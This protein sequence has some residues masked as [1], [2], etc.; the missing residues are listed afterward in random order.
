MAERPTKRRKTTGILWRPSGSLLLKLDTDTLFTV[1]AFLSVRDRLRLEVCQQL[2]HLLRDKVQW[3][4]LD[5]SIE[6]VDSAPVPP[7]VFCHRSLQ[8]VKVRVRS[9]DLG[10]GGV[11]TLCSLPCLR[12]LHLFYMELRDVGRSVDVT[13]GQKSLVDLSIETLSLRA[14][15]FT[16]RLQ[17]RVPLKVLKLVGLIVAG[18]ESVTTQ[19]EEFEM[20]RCVLLTKRSACGLGDMPNVRKM[21]VASRGPSTAVVLPD[22]SK[23]PCLSSLAWTGS[24]SQSIGSGTAPRNLTS[25]ALTGVNIDFDISTLPKLHTLELTGI[26]FPTTRCAGVVP[27]LKRLDLSSCNLRGLSPF[28]GF[29]S[30]RSLHIWNCNI[31]ALNGVGKCRDLERIIVHLIPD[32]S[33][34][35]SALGSCPKLRSASF[36]HGTLV[37]AKALRRCSNLERFYVRHCTVLDEID[38]GDRG[39]S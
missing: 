30:L 4:T 19:V 34:D 6:K 12:T 38:T 5:L 8:V 18:L 14:V 2:K 29:P 9:S 28:E 11:Q 31:T 15:S 20:F 27:S 33:L 24:R 26:A 39:Q 37:S 1:S 13:I 3:H 17:E 23:M 7:G 25:L 36:H 35:V 22:F 10:A 21:S 16:V 32:S